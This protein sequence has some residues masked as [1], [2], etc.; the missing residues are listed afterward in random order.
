MGRGLS[1]LQRFILAEAGKRER[2]H[3]CEVLAGFFGWEPNQPLRA[4]ERPKGVNFFRGRV[5][6]AAYRSAMASL[7]R[8]IRRLEGRGLVK[9]WDYQSGR[10]WFLCITDKGR[11]FL[12][13]KTAP[14][15]RAGNG[16][17]VRG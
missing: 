9:C 12:S 8:S 6:R 16:A 1:D 3:P 2:V 5:G 7:S 14:T 4:G 13:V 10:A 11:Q 15:A 17:G